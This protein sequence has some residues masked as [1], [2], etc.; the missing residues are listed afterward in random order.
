MRKWGWIAREL[1]NLGF[2]FLSQKADYIDEILWDLYPDEEEVLFT[3]D[4]RL[5]L[6]YC[7]RNLALH[8]I[9]TCLVA[10]RHVATST[11]ICVACQQTARLPDVT[12]KD[13][14][15]VCLFGEKHGICQEDGSLLSDFLEELDKTI[16]SIDKPVPQ[17][18]GE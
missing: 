16:E 2:G 4:L 7:T 14:C 10:I 9:S 15:K 3:R 18:R 5:I 11:G 8:N 12:A 17:E 13:M 1:E 6:S